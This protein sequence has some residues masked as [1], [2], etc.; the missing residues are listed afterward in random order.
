MCKQALVL[1]LPGIS[2][3]NTIS[4]LIK[5]NKVYNKFFV[6]PYGSFLF[7]KII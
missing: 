4:N 1:L 6:V 5:F 7:A 2:I 3:L